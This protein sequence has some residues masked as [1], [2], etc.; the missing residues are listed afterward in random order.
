MNG[1][2][3][4]VI[5]DTGR[6]FQLRARID[7]PGLRDADRLSH[8]RCI[9]PARDDRW[10]APCAVS[11]DV[12]GKRNAVRDAVQ[13]NRVRDGS[14]VELNRLA[15]FQGRNSNRFPERSARQR[16]AAVNLRDV[17]LGGSHHFIN[18]RRRFIHKYSDLDRREP[19]A[20]FARHIRQ[21][22]PRTLRIKNEPECRSACI[23]SYFRILAP[24]DPA[25]LDHHRKAFRAAPGSPARIRCSP[26]SSALNPASDNR[27]ASSR[28]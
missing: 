25:N 4:F 26:T 28:E 19:R 27:A 22:I 6:R 11:R 24:R 13:Q 7:A 16:V 23:H 18:R 3:L 12:P 2:H 9:Q 21:N 15:R 10:P 20:Q 14:G 17:Q 5:F 1:A 8:V